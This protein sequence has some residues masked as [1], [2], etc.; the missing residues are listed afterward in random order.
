MK[1]LKKFNE[2]EQE[3]LNEGVKNMFLIP[4]LAT[5]GY[6]N[7]QTVTPKKV[8]E[9]LFSKGKDILLNKEELKTKDLKTLFNDKSE[10]VYD[11]FKNSGDTEIQRRDFEDYCYKHN[12]NKN[13]FEKFLDMTKGSFEDF[14]HKFQTNIN[15]TKDIE[16]MFAK[17]PQNHHLGVKV[18]F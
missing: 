14:G 6:I 17:D 1:Y 10:L 13:F 9:V 18:N 3:Q 16:L 4:L 2:L 5:M 7:A 8:D 15:I 12:I 11:F